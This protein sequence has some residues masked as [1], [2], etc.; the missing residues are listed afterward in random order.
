MRSPPLR[1]LGWYIALPAIVCL[2]V[3]ICHLLFHRYPTEGEIKQRFG[4][5]DSTEFVINSTQADI[6]YF[7][8]RIGDQDEFFIETYKQWVWPGSKYN[9]SKSLPPD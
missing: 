8:I 7:G 6:G 2:I 5:S 4:K 1:T 9:W 3:V